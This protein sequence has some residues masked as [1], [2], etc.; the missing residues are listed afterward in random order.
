MGSYY[1]L[2]FN[3]AESDDMEFKLNVLLS[4]S[5]VSEATAE[6]FSTNSGKL[7]TQEDATVFSSYNAVP[8][9]S[10]TPKFD[11]N[12]IVDTNT[13]PP[14][15]SGGVVTFYLFRSGTEVE[16]DTDYPFDIGFSPQ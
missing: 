11:G 14:S 13:N 12:V 16:T 2:N 4:A 7:A 9:I 10:I 3:D 6:A 1:V 15:V 8:F 5:A